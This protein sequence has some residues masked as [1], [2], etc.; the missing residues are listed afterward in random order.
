MALPSRPLKLGR[1][2]SKL[3][4]GPR[5]TYLLVGLALAF[6]SWMLEYLTVSLGGYDGCS[7][8]LTSL[9]VFYVL[10]KFRDGV[11]RTIYV[12]VAVLSGGLALLSIVLA[13]AAAWYTFQYEPSSWCLENIDRRSCRV[14]RI[15][16]AVHDN[17]L[18]LIIAVLPQIL[19]VAHFVLVFF[20]NRRYADV[21]AGYPYVQRRR[22]RQQRD[23]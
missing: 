8:I 3:H 11:Y 19:L 18:R 4:T 14:D 9:F 1:G 12:I 2:P 13:P 20:C 5:D 15:V 7:L 17:P 22:T 21:R 10:E 6:V 23:A 16:L